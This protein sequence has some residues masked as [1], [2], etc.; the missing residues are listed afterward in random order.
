MLIWRASLAALMLL[1]GCNPAAPSVESTPLPHP[2]DPLQPTTLPSPSQTATEMQSTRGLRPD[3]FTRDLSPIVPASTP[4]PAPTAPAP[5]Q[6]AAAGSTTT[7]T[8][9]YVCP[10]HPEVT[11]PT[12]A[13]CPICKMKLVLKEPR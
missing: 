2:A 3:P 1:G 13:R 12:P 9:I 4:A 6:H 11:S 8:A 5:H 10:M 7:A